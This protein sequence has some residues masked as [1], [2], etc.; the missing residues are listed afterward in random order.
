[1]TMAKKKAFKKMNQ[2]QANV[3]VIAFVF[4]GLIVRPILWVV[5]KLTGRGCGYTPTV[6][7]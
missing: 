1:M 2:H 3:D 4:E 7:E 5:C 6:D